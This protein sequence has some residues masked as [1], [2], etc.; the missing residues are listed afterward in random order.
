MK[1]FKY[2]QSWHE[3]L[4]LLSKEER[5]ILLCAITDYAMDKK[6]T[7]IKPNAL[8]VLFLKIK[9][10]IDV[11][12]SRSS[13]GSKGGF[14][15]SKSF[16]MSSKSFDMFSKRSD[17]CSKSRAKENKEEIPPTPP[18]EENKAKKENIS[19]E[20]QKKDFQQ[21]VNSY[22]DRYPTDMLQQF[23]DYWSETNKSGTKMRYEL[24]KTWDLS[25]RLARWARNQKT[26]R[27]SNYSVGVIFNSNPQQTEQELEW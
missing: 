26:P 23:F 24:Q 13:S 6:V 11:S 4:K 19:L 22:A 7:K 10:E 5:G 1:A 2:K 20:I 3:L 12:V 18:I 25:L 8:N 15:S 27:Q 21:E 14:A 16:D 9:H 17:T